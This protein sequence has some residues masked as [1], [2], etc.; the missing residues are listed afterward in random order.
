ME[1]K[2][3]TISVKVKTQK[4]SNLVE[5]SEMVQPLLLDNTISKKDLIKDGNKDEL[6]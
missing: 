1:K 4:E 6:Q 3:S 2:N 5:N